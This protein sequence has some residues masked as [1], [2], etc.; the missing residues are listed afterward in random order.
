LSKSL[1]LREMMFDS[2][3]DLMLL[4]EIPMELSGD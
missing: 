2:A 1:Q 4:G 3:S